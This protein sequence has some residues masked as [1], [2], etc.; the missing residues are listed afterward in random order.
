[1]SAVHRVF[2]I[3]EL[4]ENIFI[5][6]P[7]YDLLLATVTCQNFRRL[8]LSSTDLRKRLQSE[9]IPV[10]ANFR[11]GDLQTEDLCNINEQTPWFFRSIVSSGIVIVL[12]TAHEDIQLHVPDAATEPIRLLDSKRT[13]VF[14]SLKAWL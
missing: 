12:R 14:T 11:A 6:L 13:R 7:L 5:H 8:V 9:P 3:Y 10:F 4:A 1:M 2:D